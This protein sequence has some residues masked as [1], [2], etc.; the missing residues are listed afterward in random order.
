MCEHCDYITDSNAKLK[1]HMRR[2]LDP[3]FKCSYCGKMLKT[4]KSLEA[5]EREHTGEKPFKCDICGNGFKSDGVLLNHKQGVH[6]VFGPK[7][8]KDESWVRKRREKV[9]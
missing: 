8:T 1:A 3:E 2:H 9:V 7:S 5:H 6:K 4:K